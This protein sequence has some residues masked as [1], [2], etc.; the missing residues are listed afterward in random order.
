MTTEGRHRGG[1]GGEVMVVSVSLVILNKSFAVLF[2]ISDGKC[3][4][5][6]LNFV[7]LTVV[8]F[9]FCYDIF[10]NRIKKYSFTSQSNTHER[11]RYAV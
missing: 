11:Q 5:I 8:C 7:V 1:G 4:W 3:E 10:D 6:V 2:H 9:D